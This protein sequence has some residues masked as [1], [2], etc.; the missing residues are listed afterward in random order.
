[1]SEK[2]YSKLEEMSRELK[3]A[4]YVP[5]TSEV[6]LDMSEEAK[7]SSVYQHSEKLAIAFG[8]LNSENGV[9]IRI[10]KNL[11]ICVDCHNAIKIVSKVYAREVVVRDRTRYHHFRHGFCSCKDYW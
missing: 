9:T 8:L 1:M 7:E 6:F 5:D 10:V 3:F 11:R 4:G 2:I